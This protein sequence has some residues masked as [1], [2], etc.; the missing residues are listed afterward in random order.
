MTAADIRHMVGHLGE[1]SERAIGQLAD[2]GHTPASLWDGLHAVL[3]PDVVEGRPL[4]SR[5]RWMLKKWAS[6]GGSPDAIPL[7]RVFHLD[8]KLPGNFDFEP[9]VSAGVPAEYF[10]A[11][12]GLGVHDPDVIARGWQECTPAEYM[13][14][15]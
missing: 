2:A 8:N 3:G 10:A 11:V 5:E 4:D 13:V 6:L 15:A 9:L 12:I 14:V 1:G 7:M